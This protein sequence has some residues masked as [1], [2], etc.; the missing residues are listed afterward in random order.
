MES[1]ELITQAG[2]KLSSF[3]SLPPKSILVLLV[4][5]LGRKMKGS[6]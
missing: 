4:G 1:Q 5:L 6:E 3:C 2:L